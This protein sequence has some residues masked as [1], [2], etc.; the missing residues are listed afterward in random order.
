[1]PSFRGTVWVP[2]TPAPHEARQ[3]RTLQTV[4]FRRLAI[5]YLG[6][7]P[8]ELSARTT[9]RPLLQVLNGEQGG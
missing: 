4:S 8:L 1:M 7:D 6:Q 9:L 2:R 5:P 3:T